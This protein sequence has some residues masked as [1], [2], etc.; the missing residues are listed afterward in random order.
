LSARSAIFDGEVSALNRT[1]QPQFTD[2]LAPGPKALVYATFDLLWLN[3]R[4]L[5]NLPLTERKERLI[6]ILPTSSG[7]VFGVLTVPERG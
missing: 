5:R 3:G 1:G 2:L 7:Q 6:R 4:D